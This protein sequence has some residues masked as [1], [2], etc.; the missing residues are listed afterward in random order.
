M[1]A[2]WIILEQ[3]ST[4]YVKANVYDVVQHVPAHVNK[5]T[6]IPLGLW[7]YKRI[8]L[9]SIDLHGPNIGT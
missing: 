4:K 6:L 3:V 7:K 9:P 5:I 2:V 1:I 8:L